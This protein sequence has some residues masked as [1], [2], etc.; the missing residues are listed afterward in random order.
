[1]QLNCVMNV[2]YL[3]GE[4]RN[5]QSCPDVSLHNKRHFTKKNKQMEKS[6]FRLELSQS[7][8]ARYLVT[9]QTF[10]LISTDGSI[11]MFIKHP[12]LKI[13]VTVWLFSFNL[14]Y[15]QT[16]ELWSVSLKLNSSK[17]VSP[18]AQQCP[19]EY[20]GRTA[21]NKTEVMVWWCEK[22]AAPWTGVI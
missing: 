1:M 6:L 3:I 18:S 17:C 15:V 7:N 20:H 4:S 21:L 2:V 8:D 19:L 13:W 12:Q 11:Q 10:T 5:I 16:S 22:M 14:P 9:K